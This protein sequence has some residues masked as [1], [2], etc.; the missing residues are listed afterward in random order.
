[1]KYCI[2][3]LVFFLLSA[4][5]SL[6]PQFSKAKIQNDKAVVYIYRP[7]KLV[8]SMGSPY[9]YINGKKDFQIHNNGYKPIVLNPGVTK[10]KVYGI[11]WSDVKKEIQ[12]RVEAGK[13][14]F[15]RFELF[16]S[17]RDRSAAIG[18]LGISGALIGKREDQQKS[19]ERFQDKRVKVESASPALFFVNPKIGA[20]EIQKS[21]LITK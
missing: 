11:I 20:Q 12:F 21:K 10:L 7:H 1:M 16:K 8:G 6:G 3:T 2:I 13:E 14:Y 17:D 9:V 18:N 5:A 15:L 19:W 4:C